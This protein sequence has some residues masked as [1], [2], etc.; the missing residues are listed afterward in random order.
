MQAKNFKDPIGSDLLEN[1]RAAF[2]YTIPAS[3]LYGEEWR[4]RSTLN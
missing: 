4:R 3:L 1:N 2:K